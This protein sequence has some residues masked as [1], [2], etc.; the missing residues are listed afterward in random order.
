MVGGVDAFVGGGVVRHDDSGVGS[1]IGVCV[2]IGVVCVDCG[3]V[4]GGVFRASVDGV[5]V[6]GVCH[7]VPYFLLLLWLSLVLPWVLLPMVVLLFMVCVCGWSC[8][9]FCVLMLSSPWMLPEVFVVFIIFFAGE[10]CVG[11]AVIMAFLHRFGFNDHSSMQCVV[12]NMHV[13]ANI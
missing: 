7:V 12:A 13:G 3:V 11:V 8:C 6:G 1:D 4:G 9:C 2:A 10:L 5:C